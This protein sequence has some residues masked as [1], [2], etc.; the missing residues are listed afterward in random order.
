MDEISI[1]NP[2]LLNLGMKFPNWVVWLTNFTISAFSTYPR[3]A[4]N[5]VGLGKASVEV[6]TI[7]PCWEL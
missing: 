5:E 6:N 1:V 7:L 2:D 4:A 3:T